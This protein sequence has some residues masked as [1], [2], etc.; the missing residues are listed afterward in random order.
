MLT[1]SAETLASHP[2]AVLDGLTVL[3]QGRALSA[4]LT[5]H[6][7]VIAGLYGL[8]VVCSAAG[9][10]NAQK[11]GRLFT[12]IASN[13]VIAQLFQIIYGVGWIFDIFF[14]TLHSQRDQGRQGVIAMQLLISLPLSFCVIGVVAPAVQLSAHSQA[15]NLMAPSY[16]Y[17]I[18]F[19]RLN[20]RSGEET[21]PPTAVE[22]LQAT[23]D[24]LEEELA[25]YKNQSSAGKLSAGRKEAK[26]VESFNARIATLEKSL[27]ATET[28]LRTLTIEHAKAKRTL[29]LKLD[30]VAAAETKSRSL[31]DA[32]EKLANKKEQA[33][34]SSSS[35]SKKKSKKQQQQQPSLPVESQEVLE[36]RARV[37]DMSRQLGVKTDEIRQAKEDIATVLEDTKELKK[38]LD[39]L[40]EEVKVR[41]AEASR[42]EAELAFETSSNAATAPVAP[43]TRP[44]SASSNVDVPRLIEMVRD[45]NKDIA[46]LRAERTSLMLDLA[47]VKN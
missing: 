3:I 35:S 30:E 46:T 45:L 31:E 6:A 10:Y 19:R 15:I 1:I 21:A 44:P 5:T 18:D 14:V 8:T 23:V 39:C 16:P 20:N 4:S 7:Y 33:K 29:A 41:E 28:E 13:A 9:C 26:K 47:G 37:D 12:R 2:L 11:G 36:L 22:E 25:S 34:P 43:I 17:L 27:N 38:E 32:L 24:R 40:N 42:L